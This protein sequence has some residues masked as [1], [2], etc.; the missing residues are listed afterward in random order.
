MTTQLP[1]HVGRQTDVETGYALVCTAVTDGHPDTGA[2]C[3]QPAS[4]HIRWEEATTENGFACP[5]HLAL[6]L[7]LGFFGLHGV[8]DSA[9]GLPG[10]WWVSG[11]PSHCAMTVLDEEPALDGAHLVPAG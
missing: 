11:P 9:C 5:V 8:K 1:E 6:A 4:H 2:L 3:G 7:I 10:A